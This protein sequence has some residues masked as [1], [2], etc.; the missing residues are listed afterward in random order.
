M[1]HV[2]MQ[3]IEAIFLQGVLDSGRILRAC[4]VEGPFELE[5][6]CSTVSNLGDEGKSS[7]KPITRLPRIYRIYFAT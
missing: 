1:L 5:D 4:N 7:S 2:E 3:I 6:Q